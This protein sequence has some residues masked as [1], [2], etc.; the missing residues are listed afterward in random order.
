MILPDI[1]VLTHLV[2]TAAR[3]ELL[4]SFNQVKREFKGNGSVV[5]RVDHAMQAR[6]A[7]TLAEHWPTIGFLGEEMTKAEQINRQ[8]AATEGLWV[9]DP[10]DG[11][12]NFAAGIPFYSVS[13]ALLAHGRVVMGVVYDPERD[14]MFHAVAGGGAWLNGE[15]LE[16]VSI[17]MPLENC[18]G[19][20]DFKRL[21]RDLALRLAKGPPYSSQRSFGSV[22]LD[23]CWVAADRFHVYVH[24][25]QKLWDYAAGLLILEEAGGHAATLDGEAVFEDSIASR[26]AIAAMNGPLFEAWRAWILEG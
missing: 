18:V 21:P 25:R 1:D 10:L 14:E 8:A 19:A 23:W 24:G 4:P 12:T 11:T 15:R 6:L 2:R 7:A 3:E 22:A 13:L 9:L 20:V 5:T 26:S 17:A 16:P